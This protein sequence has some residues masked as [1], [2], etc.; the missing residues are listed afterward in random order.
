MAIAPAGSSQQL[1]AQQQQV[2]AQLRTRDQEVRLHEEAHRAAAGPYAGTPSYQYTTGPDGRRYAVGGEVSID[3]S[4]VQ[5][6][7]EA[8]IAKMR[9]VVRAALAPSQPS[10]QDRAV[11]AQ[12][13]V[14]LALAQAEKSKSDE[15]SGGA[16]ADRPPLTEAIAA[17]ARAA[18]LK[19][20]G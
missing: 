3:A 10:A 6:N 16:A 2:V 17:Y 8:T 11:A 4:P 20:A 12:A 5:G 9:I 19:P 13:Q 15:G 14:L 1:S 18:S 7:P